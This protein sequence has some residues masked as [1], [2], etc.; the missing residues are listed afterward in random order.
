MRKYF[1]CSKILIALT[2]SSGFMEINFIGNL[3]INIEY[4]RNY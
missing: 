3:K 2:I 4:S 1:M